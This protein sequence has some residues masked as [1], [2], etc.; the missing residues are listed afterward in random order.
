M[1]VVTATQY[2]FM[3]MWNGIPGAL[4]RSF[5]NIDKKT[6]DS[7]KNNNDNKNKKKK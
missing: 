7:N 2:A 5:E 4:I 1:Y 6:K 3:S